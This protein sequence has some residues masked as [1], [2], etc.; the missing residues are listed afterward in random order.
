M[1]G[2]GT[3]AIA[4]VFVTIAFAGCIG[5]NGAATVDQTATH[6][7]NTLTDN[8]TIAPNGAGK[9][10]AFNETNK[11]ETTGIGSML[12]T[13]DYWKGETRKIVY[14]A[15]LGLIP[16]PL[17]PCKKP[18]CDA[19]DPSQTYPPGTAIADFDIPAPPDGG[20]VYEGT[21]HLEVVFKDVRVLYTGGTFRG[22]PVPKVDHPY[23]H[24]GL[25][26]LT[27]AD[28]PFAF[29]TGPEVTPG[30]PIIIPVKPLDADMPHQTKSLWVF[31]IYTKEA[32]AWNFNFTVTAVKGNA[33]VNW[34]P[35]P[36]LYADRTQRVIFDGEQKISSNGPTYMVDGNDAGWQFPDRVLSWGTDSVDVIVS[37]VQFTSPAPASPAKYLLEYHNASFI[38]KLGNGDQAGGRV[39]DPGS[40]GKTYRFSIKVDPNGYDTPYGQKSRWGFRFVPRYDDTSCPQD[41]TSQQFLTGCQW[42]PWT[43]TYHIQI[44]A[45]GH[46]IETGTNDLNDPNGAQSVPTAPTK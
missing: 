44:I 37:N 24:I 33:I 35:H 34:P 30:T 27:A 32:N 21:D 29:H 5:N 22:V 4:L 26:Y 13:H 28:E 40:D 42:F 36:N 20:L 31:R 18:G 45:H 15:N 7:N 11:T 41:D 9:I 25:D 2:R 12:H 23:I 6:A 38:S 43:E 19:K 8:Q 14:Q 17:V 3:P 10:S 1:L 46:S 16:L 39:T